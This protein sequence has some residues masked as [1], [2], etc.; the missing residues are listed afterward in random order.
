MEESLIREYNE[1]FNYKDFFQ[2]IEK[3][4]QR[5]IAWRTHFEPRDIKSDDS[6]PTYI[7]EEAIPLFQDCGEDDLVQ[8]R[9]LEV[10]HSRRSSSFDEFEYTWTIEQLSI[11]LAYSAGNRPGDGL[12]L[13]MDVP[14]RFRTYPSGGAMYSVLLFFIA[15]GVEGLPDGLYRYGAEEHIL[16]RLRG[17]VDHK[18]I[19]RLFPAS[20]FQ[21]PVSGNSLTNASIFIFFISNYRYLFQKYGFA[22][23]PLSLIESGH[24]CQNIQL[25]SAALGQTSRPIAGMFIDRIEELLNIRRNKY[26]HCIYSVIL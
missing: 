8:K 19:E 6:L 14:V 11:L 25:L 5:S 15:K 9:L 7:Y 21:S 18:E 26:L 20:Q 17:K 2:F 10:L 23:Y 3:Y 13:D 16:Y 22:S 1:F 12:D 4:K 24:I